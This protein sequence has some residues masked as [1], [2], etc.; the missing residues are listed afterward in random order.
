MI[1][2][3]AVAWST[4]FIALVLVFL[5][6]RVLSAFGVVRPL[7]LGVL[8]I[9]GIAIA[10]AGALLALWCILTFALIGKGT[11]APFDP[12]RHLVI[13]GPY[14]YVRNP[15]YIGAGLALIGA[16]MLYRSAALVGYLLVLAVAIHAL[17]LGYEEPTLTRLFGA[18]YANYRAAV[19]R[20]VP[21]VPRGF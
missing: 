11:P 1:L 9:V 3:R 18:D 20:W 2:A 15:M 19:R 8:G 14:R 12:P 13:R 16:A 4:L 17:V 6:A 7:A 5:P 10:F 21:R